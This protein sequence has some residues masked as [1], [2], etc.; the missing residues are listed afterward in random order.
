MLKQ[1]PP[2]ADVATDWDTPLTFSDKLIAD[3]GPKA[4]SVEEDPRVPRTQSIEWGGKT[5]A[6]INAVTCPG[7]HGLPGKHV[8]EDAVADMLIANHY[9]IFGRSPFRVEA[10]YQDNFSVSNPTLRFVSIPSALTYALPAAMICR[11]SA[12][13]AGV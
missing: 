3:R 7:A 6:Q 1:Y 13:I 9:T 4:M 8:S 2:I 10:I 12:A 11:I 5:V